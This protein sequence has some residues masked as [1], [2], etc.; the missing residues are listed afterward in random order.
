ML[1]IAAAV[2]LALGL[3]IRLFG[4]QPEVGGWFRA[5]FGEVFSVAAAGLAAVLGAPAGIGLWAMAGSNQED[6]VPALS[7]TVRR[8]F[9]GLGVGIT[10]LTAVV[11][12]VTGSGF[13][14]V[15][16]GLIGLVA[17]A[18]LGLA[19]ATNFSTRRVRAAVSAATL[20][21]VSLG[22][23]WVLATVFLRTPAA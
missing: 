13:A 12:L 8:V 3:A 15:N 10:A 14:I 1:V 21:L 17:L 6:A 5:I 20:I 22:A 18:S 9:V 19:G 7:P 16:L 2:L 23:L 4:E 11:C